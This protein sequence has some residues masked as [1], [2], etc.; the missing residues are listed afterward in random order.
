MGNRSSSGRI[1]V[2][3][4]LLENPLVVERRRAIVVIVRLDSG[5]GV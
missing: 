3:L 2:R 4:A 1:V 5:A